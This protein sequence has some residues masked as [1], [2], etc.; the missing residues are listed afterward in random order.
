MKIRTKVRVALFC[1]GVGLGWT[2]DSCLAR[3]QTAPQIV[4]LTLNVIL[5]EPT[6]DATG[7]PL[8]ATTAMTLYQ[9]W[10]ATQPIP[11]SPSGYPTAGSPPRTGSIT[12]SIAEPV[13]TV[14]HV[15]VGACNQFGC[16]AYLS[17]EQTIVV[18]ALPQP[19]TNVTVA[20]NFEVL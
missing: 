18:P 4:H 15:R 3:A 10:V 14:V 19:P 6:L 2:G 20:M 17:P 9:I 16:G 1:L 8:T 7:A 5:S 11:D 13:G 12:V